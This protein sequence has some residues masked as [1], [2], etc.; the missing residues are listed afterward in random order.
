[1]GV[2]FVIPVHNEE[3][4]IASV[5]HRIFSLLNG[6]ICFEVI[7]IDNASTDGSLSILKSF[8]AIK[9]LQVPC[10]LTISA[11]RNLGWKQATYDLI[12]FIDGDV[13]ITTR[14]VDE[15][16]SMQ[17]LLSE[18]NMLSGAT[19]SISELPG[20]IESSWFA[21]MKYHKRR[22]I[23]GGNIITSRT[24][25]DKLGGFNELLISAED[26]DICRRAM[27]LGL[28]V[29]INE[30]LQVLHEGYPKSWI[31]FFRRELWH[32]VGDMQSF[33]RFINSKTALA[34]VFQ[35]TL[36]LSSMTVM[37]VSSEI[38]GV[39]GIF[40][41]STLNLLLVFKKFHVLRYGHLPQLFLLMAIYQAARCLSIFRRNLI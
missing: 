6:R 8:S 22:Y 2:S 33:H 10:K 24:T 37:L 41:F 40:I 15:L 13:L 23:N 32:G 19:Y 39:I 7:V 17:G 5:L 28:R 4:F 11:V 16:I 25:L 3:Q 38:S 27:S 26:V 35:I 31:A 36:L 34:A 20:W 1:M 12:A 21:A 29:C 9:L 30:R 14:W 18:G